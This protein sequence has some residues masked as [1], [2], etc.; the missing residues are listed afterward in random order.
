VYGACGVA[1][2]LVI[3]LRGSLL[4]AVLIVALIEIPILSRACD[5]VV[6]L[7]PRE[8]EEAVLSLGAGHRTL[9]FRVVM[10]EVLSGLVTAGLL[11]FGRGIGDAAAVLLVA[12]FQDGIPGS[13]LEPVATLPLTIFFL[14]N[15]PL[16]EVRARGYAAGLVL[17]LIIVL[18]SAVTRWVGKKY[19]RYRIDH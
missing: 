2:M 8:L 18:I 10:R 4:A 6:R 17:I 1:V 11:A 19:S 9:A 15:T 13:L 5:E 14:V 12:G 7:V 3:G 16:P